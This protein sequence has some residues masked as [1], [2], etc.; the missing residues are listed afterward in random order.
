MS[1]FEIG[2]CK[3][4]DRLPLLPVQWLSFSLPCILFIVFT[5]KNVNIK[6]KLT[7]DFFN[8]GNPHPFLYEPFSHTV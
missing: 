8:Y 1:L 5:E 7:F 3:Y 4:L 6:N 2:S